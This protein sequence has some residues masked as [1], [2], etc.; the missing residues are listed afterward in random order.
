[1]II[2]SSNNIMLEKTLVDTSKYDDDI[3]MK[4]PLEEFTKEIE[5]Y[6]S[7]F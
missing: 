5:K 1:N 7:F 3:N 4:L 2:L 6:K